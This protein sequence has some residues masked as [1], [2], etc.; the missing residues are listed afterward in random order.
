MRVKGR[1]LKTGTG[2]SRSLVVQASRL[3]Q[4]MQAG[5]LHHR[6]C[7][8]DS[9]CY[10]ALSDGMAWAIFAHNLPLGQIAS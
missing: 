3:P 8:V 2:T 4:K 9:A 5:R 6:D 7:L 10:E 1:M